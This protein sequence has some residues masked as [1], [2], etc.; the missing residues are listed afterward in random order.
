[1]DYLLGVL[2]VDRGKGTEQFFPFLAETP[3]EERRIWEQFLALS[4][5]YPEAPIFHFSEYE[6]EAVE[7]LARRYQTPPTRLEPILSRFVDLHAWTMK[8]AT[9]PVES[10]SLKSLAGWL[11][12]QW[13]DR[14]A[15]G[16]V[17]V[18]WYD[19]WLLGG[20]RAWLEAIVRY[21]EDDCRATYLLKDWLTRFLGDARGSS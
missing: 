17:A 1:L 9:L 13:R 4:G 19:R 7:R 10:Y 16:E 15:S 21:N 2:L 5:R 20:D 3:D 12:F 6:A 18:C 14:G 11:G 8:S